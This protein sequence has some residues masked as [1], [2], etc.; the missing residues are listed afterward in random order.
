MNTEQS[1]PVARMFAVRKYAIIFAAALIVLSLIAGR[2]ALAAYTILALTGGFVIATIA[3]WFYIFRISR[4]LHGTGYA[5]GHLAISVVLT[6]VFLT[7][8]ILMPL[9]IRGDAERLA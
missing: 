6:P 8:L 3:T 1:L 2:N 9:L 7:G 4:S 5:V